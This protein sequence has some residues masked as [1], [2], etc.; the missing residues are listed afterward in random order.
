MPCDDYSVALCI[1]EFINFILIM[2]IFAI[3][4]KEMHK[5]SK[6]YDSTA[7]QLLIWHLTQTETR[8]TKPLKI[9]HIAICDYVMFS[10]ICIT[11]SN[12]FNLLQRVSD[13]YI[14]RICNEN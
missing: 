11:N 5:L 1:T 2:R 12:E 13:S 3:T 7:I 6:C 10:K 9:T 4:R 14:Q 8:L